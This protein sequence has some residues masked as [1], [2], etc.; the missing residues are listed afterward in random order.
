[1]GLLEGTQAY[2]RHC[3]K[4]KNIATNLVLDLGGGDNENKESKPDL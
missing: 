4:I 2:Q 3:A 1:M